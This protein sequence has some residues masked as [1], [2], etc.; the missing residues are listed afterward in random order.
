MR[1]ERIVA[2]AR[3]IV[4]SQR[5]RGEDQARNAGNEERLAP[6]EIAIYEPAHDV[7][8]R[9]ADGNRREEYR[10]DAA[11]LV[12]REVIGEEGGG[13]GAV[14]RLPD[15]DHG[16]RR[17]QPDVVAR[18]PG[19]RGGDAPDPDAE[20]QQT[21]PRAFVAEGAEQR[22]GEH[23]HDEKAGHERA[24]LAIRQTQF[25]MLHALGERGDD[26]PIQ[27]VE[28]IDQRQDSETETGAA[29]ERSRARSGHGRI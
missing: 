17:E 27:V 22:C 2:A 16:S 28:E 25:G 13:D 18:Q 9:R 21:G 4:Q 19:K 24:E 26:P 23:V 15:A 14:R 10:E 12:A 6:S 29:C 8:E 5:Q 1:F 11:A 3:G 7:S 20:A